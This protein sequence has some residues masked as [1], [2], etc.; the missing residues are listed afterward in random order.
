MNGPA[1]IPPFMAAW[2]EAQQAF[3]QLAG[4]GQAAD[5]AASAT[6]RLFADQYR[7]LFRAPGLMSAPAGPSPTG[8]AQ[9]RYQQAA[10]GFG[11][12]LNEAALDA[13]RR[14][15]AALAAGGPGAP[16]ITTLRE[17]HSLWIDCGEAA[18]STVAHRDDFAAALAELL[19]ALVTVGVAEPAG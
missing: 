14:L 4:L 11:V 15:G 6:Q 19:A 17:L 7:L 2:L 1:G 10:L 12:L 8:A 13:G 18:W 5:P 3:G 9:L 16:P